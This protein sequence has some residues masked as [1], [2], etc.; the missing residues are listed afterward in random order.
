M[1]LETLLT[2]PTECEAKG[3][4]LTDKRRGSM[5]YCKLAHKNFAKGRKRPACYCAQ[6]LNAGRAALAS[7]EPSSSEDTGHA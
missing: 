4:P 6:M 1:K 7:A 2:P 3:L 5:W